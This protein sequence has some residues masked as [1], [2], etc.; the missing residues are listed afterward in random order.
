MNIDFTYSP[1]W[2]LAGLVFAAGLSFFLYYKD[3]QLREL[4]RTWVRVLAVLRFLFI[5]GIVFLL[6]GPSLNVKKTEKEEPVFIIAQDNSASVLLNADSALYLNEYPQKIKSINSKLSEDYDVHYLQF[7]DSVQDKE[8]LDFSDAVTNFSD[9]MFTLQAGYTGRHVAGML[10]AS[11]GL[12]NQGHHP[13]HQFSDLPY[14]VFTLA[15]AD[16]TQKKDALINDVNYNSIAFLNNRFPVRVHYHAYKLEGE[17]MKIQL[18]KDDKVLLQKQVD[19][20]TENITDHVDLQIKADETGLQTYNIIIEPVEGEITRKNNSRR[21][22]V[23]VIDNQQHIVVIAAAPHPDIAAIHRALKQNKNFSVDIQYLSEMSVNI[24]DAD[25][26]IC[27]QVPAKNNP[28]SSVFKTTE[29]KHIPVLFVFGLQSDLRAFNQLGY[30]LSIKTKG[31]SM[32][33]AQALH[34]QDFKHFSLSSDFLDILETLPPLY[35]PFADFQFTGEYSTVFTQKINGINT[36]KPLISLSGMEQRKLAFVSGTGLWKWRMT[37][38][39]QNGNHD[40]FDKMVNNLIQY[41]VT[42]STGKQFSVTT[43]QITSENQSV[44]FDAELYNEAYELINDPEVK[45]YIEDSTGKENEYKFNRSLHA[46]QLNLGSLPVG[47]YAWRAQ[48]EY[49]NNTFTDEGIF[50]VE[51]VSLEALKTRANHKILAMISKNTGAEMFY[52]GDIE[53][54]PQ[55]LQA[56]DINKTRIITSQSHSVLLNLKWIFFLLLGLISVEWFFRKF[57]GGY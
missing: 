52:P 53:T 46:Y 30:N 27:H 34:N 31:E 16:T 36:A 14:P 7:G 42:Q 25:L 13:L 43:E 29:T 57:F 54:I 23:N 12:Y 6:L 44:I 5:F 3:T 4:N 1:W 28:A 24:D 51:P 2:L 35:V 48:V 45:L 9:L 41:L 56:Y 33:Y 37:T 40:G 19:I 20:N 49:E 18:L 15:L 21:I 38:Y 50:L 26:I 47:K 39:V 32:D 22:S 8:N 55:R 17:T 11:D 10:L